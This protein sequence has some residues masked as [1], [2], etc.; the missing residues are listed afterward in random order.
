MSNFYDLEISNDPAVIEAEGRAGQAQQFAV[1][2]VPITGAIVTIA[3][4]VG[5]DILISGSNGVTVSPAANTITI[6]LSQNLQTSGSPTFNALTVTNAIGAGSLT[7]TTDL[8]VTHGGTGA[9]DAANART[10]LGIDA[11]ATKLSNL[12]AAVAPTVNEDSG[13][14]YDVGSFWLDT[15]ADDAYICLDAAVGAAVWRKITP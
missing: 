4:L 15:T 13:D 1:V 12:S 11:I 7:L 14:G 10:N 9:S 8:A 3:G 5:P 2:A 6:S